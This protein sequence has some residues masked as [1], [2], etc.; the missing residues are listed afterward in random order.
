MHQRG[1]SELRGSVAGE[2]Q[3]WHALSESRWVH[4]SSAGV[5]PESAQADAVTGMDGGAYDV[6]DPQGR[7]N[8]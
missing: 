6:W 4:C 2:N 1:E 7:A 8:A 3:G 5:S